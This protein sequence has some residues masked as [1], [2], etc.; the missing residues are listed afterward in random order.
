MLPFRLA[1][2]RA[3][4]GARHPGDIALLAVAQGDVE[5]LPL[6]ADVGTRELEG[7]LRNK[8]GL[9]TLKE[10]IRKLSS[11]GMALSISSFVAQKIT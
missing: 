10:N 11:I 5:G 1:G 9:K 8:T 4:R 2:L 7:A 6:F 3:C